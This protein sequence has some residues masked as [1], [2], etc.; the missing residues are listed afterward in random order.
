MKNE[1]ICKKCGK[2]IKSS[3]KKVF[4]SRGCA[5]AFYSLKRYNQIKDTPNYKMKRRIYQKFHR[6]DKEGKDIIDGTNIINTKVYINRR[7]GQLSLVLP[8]KQLPG[9]TKEFLKG[10]YLNS[11]INK[12]ITVEFNKYLD[13][14]VI[15]SELE[16]NQLSEYIQK[17]I[18]ESLSEKNIHKKVELI[19]EI[20]QQKIDYELTN[21]IQK[22]LQ[23][24]LKIEIE[25]HLYNTRFKEEIKEIII[26]QVK[27]EIKIQL[28]E[29]GILPFIRDCVYQYIRTYGSKNKK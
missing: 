13:K 24:R 2:L 5:T 25:D 4:C 21:Q 7:T 23:E 26:K 9:I 12:L 28:S 18:T 1:K 17:A 16:S 11:E 10:G 14:K 8:K 15:I 20:L 19:N 6:G 3:K 27:D 22:I 29:G